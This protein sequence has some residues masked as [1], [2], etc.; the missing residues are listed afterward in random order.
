MKTIQHSDV[1]TNEILE[2][3]KQGLSIGFVPTMG[4]LHKGHFSLIR[5]CKSENDICICSIFVNPTQF[6]QK[7]DLEKYPRTP[8]AD[9]DSLRTYNCDILFAPAVED[10]YP[11]GMEYD[12]EIDLEG[13]DETM[14][15]E[16]RPGHFKGVVQVVKRLLDITRCDKLYMGQK[17]YQ[18]F[19]IIN[20]LISVFNMSVQLIVCPTERA[21]DGLALSSRNARLTEKQRRKASIIYRVLNQS[22]IWLEEGLSP[23]EIRYRAMEYLDLPLFHPEYFHIVDGYTLSRVSNPDNHKVVVACTAVWT[24][25]VR[26]IDN[27]ILK[28]QLNQ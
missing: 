10:I 20:K 7:S 6:N 16:K 18:Q 14:E 1:L 23:V 9:A 28:G 2:K 15:G 4:A 8:E 19:T 22:K 26:L 24:G 17:D 21:E 5:K 12:L 27:M 11:D 3:K 25:D 13:L